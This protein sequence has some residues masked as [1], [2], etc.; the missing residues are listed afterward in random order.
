MLTQVQLSVTCSIRSA[1]DICKIKT[2][3]E[4]GAQ[5]LI[6]KHINV[7]LNSKQQRVKHALISSFG[8]G[9]PQN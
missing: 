9:S 3:A 8:K 4:M 7:T 5:N 6:D 2:R 1:L